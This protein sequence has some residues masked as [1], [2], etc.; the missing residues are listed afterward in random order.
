MPK[1]SVI[2]PSFNSEKTVSMTVESALAQTYPDIEVI[3]VDD[4]STDGTR[5]ILEPYADRIRY[6]YQE[7]KKHSGARNTGI[8]AAQGEYLAFLDS[9]DLWLPEKIERQVAV[10]DQHP[11]VVLVACVARYI[12]QQGNPARSSGRSLERYSGVV[13]APSDWTRRLF[14][15]DAV[16]GGGSSAMVRREALLKAGLFDEGLDYAEDWDTWMRVSFLGKFVLIPDALLLFRVSDWE[17][18]LRREASNE[19]I[20]RPLRLLE[21]AAG[22]WQGD[23]RDL[24]ELLRQGTAVLW[25]RAALASIQMGQFEQGSAQYAKM[26]DFSPEWA[27]SQK[28]LEM[29]LDRARLIDQEYDDIARAESFLRNYFLA[30]PPLVENSRERYPEARAWL[31]YGRALDEI[32]AEKHGAARRD[33]LK[34]L[35]ISGKM[36]S[37]RGFVSQ[38]VELFLG[39]AVANRLRGRSK[40]THA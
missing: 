33:W 25:R 29:G 39:R 3:V 19:L 36:L 9:D 7:N 2:I 38:G 35:F 16:P 26:L 8:R 5:Q 18:K 4:G 14:L 32:Q 11:E 17:R 6:I 1:V 12:D 10:L 15:G 37:N 27:T 22:L 40:E 24:Q 30:L 20:T 34:A 31:W 23:P 21:K 28:V 13:E